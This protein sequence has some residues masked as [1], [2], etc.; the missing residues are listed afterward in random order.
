MDVSFHLTP[1]LVLG[2]AENRRYEAT[3]LPGSDLNWAMNSA[4]IFVFLLDL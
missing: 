2:M 4:S 1:S 3:Y